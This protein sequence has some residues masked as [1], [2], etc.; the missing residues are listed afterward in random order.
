MPAI[1]LD[2]REVHLAT[3]LTDQFIEGVYSAFNGKWFI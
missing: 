1:S 2:F 3:L